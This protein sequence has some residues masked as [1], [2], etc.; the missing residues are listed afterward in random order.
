MRQVEESTEFRLDWKKL[1]KAAQ[2]GNDVVPVCVQDAATRQVL[3]V[4][5]VNQVALRETQRRRVCVLWS[6]SRQ[7]LWVKGETSG[8]YL[9]LVSILVNCEQNSLLFLVRPRQTGACHTRD[10]CGRTRL[11]CYYRTLEADDRLAFVTP[12][13]SSPSYILAAAATSAIATVLF[14]AARRAGF[15]F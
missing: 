13:S 12:P 6:T 1:A 4:A 8:D 3:I 11:S 5:Y 7:K 10:D 14:I 15:S 2:G 9:D